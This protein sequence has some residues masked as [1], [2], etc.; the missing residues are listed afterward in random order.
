MS[1]TEAGSVKTCL[2]DFGYAFNDKGQLRQ[3]DDDG[4]LTD[5]P[6]NFQISSSHSE[7]Q[8]NYEAIGEVI[9]D[10]VYK[11]LD[12]HGM[13]RINVPLGETDLSKSTFVF[14]TKE[15]LVDVDK[16]MIL[17]HGSGVVRAGQCEFEICYIVHS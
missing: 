13:H 2:K 11:L 14:S 4:N 7:N 15:E 17:I 5:E 1:S 8:K 16:L 12:E 9:T 6:F 3:L 10:E